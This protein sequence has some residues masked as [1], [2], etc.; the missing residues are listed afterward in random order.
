MNKLIHSL[1]N[2]FN[3]IKKRTLQ[4]SPSP[5]AT[6]MTVTF[7]V[8]KVNTG[9]NCYG[10]SGYYSFK[11]TVYVLTANRDSFDSY[12]ALAEGI[13]AKENDYIF[14]ERG[15]DV[16]ESASLIIVDDF[17]LNPN[18]VEILRQL[19]KGAYFNKYNMTNVS[20]SGMYVPV[21]KG[22]NQTTNQSSQP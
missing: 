6:M 5:Y 12:L 15:E 13:N 4:I 7:P 22:S 11:R 2:L 19:N 20:I 21:S 17:C 9:S 10:T 18:C 1:I 8:V 14:V 3:P 16:K